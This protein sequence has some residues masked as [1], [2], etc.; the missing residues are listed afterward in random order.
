MRDELIAPSISLYIKDECPDIIITYS[1]DATRIIKLYVKT[2]I[3]VITMFHLSPN[4]VLE[5]STPVTKSMLSKSEII[6]VLTPKYIN[7]VKKFVNNNH[8]ICIPNCV[9]NVVLPNSINEIKED[10]IIYPARIDTGKRQHLLIEAFNLINKSFPTWKV[11]FWGD[12]SVNKKYYKKLLLMVKNY[13]LQ[14]KV[15]FK[16]VTKNIF[17]ELCRAK[18]CAFPSESEGFS[19]AL[20]EALSAELPAVGFKNSDFIN[21]VIKNDIN[22]YLCEDNIESFANAILEI[23]VSD[24]LRIKLGIG[25]R[26]SVEQYSENYVWEKWETIIKKCVTENKR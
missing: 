5:Q 17:N 10:L 7:D 15:I 9:P 1:Q 26:Q 21:E 13:D 16:G 18:I 8:I 23:M 20:T 22:G 3:P 2:N 24:N 12:T 19:L 6:Q 14:D 25:A 11:E 4:S